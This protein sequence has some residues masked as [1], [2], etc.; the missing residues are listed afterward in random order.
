MSANSS[1]DHAPTQTLQLPRRLDR[2]SALSLAA[3]LQARRGAP[4]SLKGAEVEQLGAFGLQALLVAQ[5]SWE[6]DGAAFRIFE[7]SDAMKAD[8]E[9]MGVQ[10]D[11]LKLEEEA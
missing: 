7:A 9:T 5:A 10:P 8:L 11:L 6:R 1:A 4:I 2:G 3:E